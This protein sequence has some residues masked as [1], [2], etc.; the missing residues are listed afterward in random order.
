MCPN[1]ASQ[2]SQPYYNYGMGNSPST[3]NNSE[4][5]LIHLYNISYGQGNTNALLLDI[6]QSLKNLYVTMGTNQVLK[7]QSVIEKE[8][9]FS[10]IEETAQGL[11]VNGKTNFPHVICPVHIDMIF[12]IKMDPLYQLENYYIIY[13]TNIDNP[14]MHFVLLIS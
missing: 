9:A 13:F 11:C 4:Q 7:E 1:N 5:A 12:R 2:Y 6:A 14:L 10:R 3:P 8:E